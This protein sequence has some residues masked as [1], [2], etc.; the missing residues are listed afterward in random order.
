MVSAFKKKSINAMSGLEALPDDLAGDNSVQTYS[1]PTTNA[2]MAF[3][4][5]SHAPLNDVKLRQALVQSVDRSSISKLSSSP[6]HPVDSPLLKGQLGYDSS[7]TELPYDPVAAGTLLDQDGWVKDSTGFRSKGGQPLTI[8]MV[9]QNN[10]DY[11][12]TASFLQ[13]QW[14]KIGVKINVQYYS[15]DDM[16]T[17]VIANHSYDILLYGIN[18]GSDPD[19][20]AY[21]DSSQASITS[22]GHLNLSE[23][24][25][26]AADEALEFGRTRP[27]PKLRTIKYKAFLTAWRTD[28]PALALYQTNYL[29]ITRGPVFNFERKSINS[30]ADRFDNVYSWMIRQKRLDT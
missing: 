20:F 29:Y 22:Q 11:T 16:Q 18:I 12:K 1:T 25:S 30:P 10:Q 26:T 28:A 4:N 3:F 9:T 27:D 21:W 24:K 2:V 8:T 17:S 13:Q 23:Y 15:S 14:Q 5:T 7:D 6:L 19:V